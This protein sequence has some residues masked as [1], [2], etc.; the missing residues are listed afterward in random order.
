MQY[1]VKT[2]VKH[3]EEDVFAEGCQP[4]TGGSYSFNCR[5]RADSVEELVKKINDFIGNDDL[6][7]VELDACDEA[8]RIDVQMLETDDGTAPTERQ[9]ERWKAGELR[10]WLADYSFYVEAVERR[11]VELAPLVWKESAAE[12][13]EG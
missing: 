1:E 7:A 4:G 6:G 12:R 2:A 9:I 13:G 5:L 10:L 11:T 3:W 8:G